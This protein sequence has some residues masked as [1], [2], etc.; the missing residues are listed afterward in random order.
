MI[1]ENRHNLKIGNRIE[2]V[3]KVNYLVKLEVTR[4]SEKSCWLC[5]GR[6]S[7]NTVNDYIENYN[8]KIN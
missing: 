3:N 5:G 2:F 8:A 7:W 6:N 4:I 1:Q